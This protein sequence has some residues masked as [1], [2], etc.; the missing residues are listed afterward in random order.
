MPFTAHTS[1]APRSRRA[2]TWPLVVGCALIVLGFVGWL[3][4]P[5]HAFDIH[6]LLAMRNPAD[7]AQLLGP[8]WLQEMLRD[9]MGLGG[10]GV[11]ILFIAVGLGGLW[12]ADHRR[13]A[14]WFL[15]N[16]VGAFVIASVLKHVLARPRPELIP[17]AAYTFTASF[18]SGHTMMATVVWLWLALVLG[19]AIGKRAARAWLVTGALVIAFLV[20]AS[21]VYMGVHWPSDVVESW[22]LG[23]AW[24]WVLRAFKR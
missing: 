11:V 23:I 2:P 8:R 19:D 1:L 21:R 14:F 3:V 22:G 9:F 4:A 10:E 24:V 16:V 17:H 20:G 7:P 6:T 12:L 18:P 13:E 5:A 15:G